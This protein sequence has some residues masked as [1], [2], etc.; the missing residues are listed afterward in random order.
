MA[1]KSYKGWYT[2]SN[3]EKFVPPIDGYMKSFNESTMQVEYKSSLE[4]KSFMY[5]CNSSAVK[6]WS[7]EPYPIH[8]LKP[9]DGMQHRYYPDLW[10]EFKSGKKVLVEVKS[11]GET[12]EP[13]KP[14][15]M[16][17][18]AIR[19]YKRA[20]ITWSINQAKWEAAQEFC[21]ENDMEFMLLTERQLNKI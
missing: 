5:C 17:Q 12:Q 8:Y 2:I 7:V 19:R 4:L 6:K 21:K 1:F 10:I 11:S 16:N 18:N 15:K 9:T 14:K 20:L 3:P 13:K